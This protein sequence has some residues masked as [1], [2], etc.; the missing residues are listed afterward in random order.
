VG[1]GVSDPIR[2]AEVVE[3]DRAADALLA[4]HVALMQ[5]QTQPE[6]CHVMT[7]ADLCAAGAQVFAGRDGAGAVVAIGAIKPLGDG[8][9]ELKSMHCAQARRG[10][11]LG[12]A[13]L[14]HLV[15]K[16]RGMGAASL[17][18]ETGSGEAFAAARAL[19]RSEGFAECGPFGDYRQDPLS[20]FMTRVL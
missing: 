3:G 1:E 17:W 2:F 11:G 12:R 5:A 15:E 10:E 18:L 9:A 6:S 8:A 16:A 14:R 19:Y 20:V 13:L 7:A 4:A